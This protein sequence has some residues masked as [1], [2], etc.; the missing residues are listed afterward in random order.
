MSDLRK[1]Y[2]LVSE[3]LEN[4]S[5]KL[6]DVAG[7]D[8]S[9][10]SF[11]I[12]RSISRQMSVVREKVDELYKRINQHPEV[13]LYANMHGYS[14]VEPYEIVRIV[15]SKMIEVRSMKCELAKDWKPEVIIG[16]FV[17]HTVNNQSQRWTIES[18]PEGSLMKLRLNVKG[19]WRSKA[20]RH[21]I[22][23]RPVKFYD[24]NF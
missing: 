22:H 16:G 17:G 14:D 18:D 23:F 12:C 2:D 24:Y 10:E 9:S 1:E 21:S 3:E 20:G 13:G 4:L 5:V 11:E 15:N 19:E 7:S 6:H 8:H